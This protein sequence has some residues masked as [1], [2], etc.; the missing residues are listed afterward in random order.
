M[1]VERL[2]IQNF[3][4]FAAASFAPHTE[5]NLI[6]GPN[7]S[8][9]TTLLE[10]MH[11]LGT[12]RSFRVR[13]LSPL[14]RH[15]EEQF[16]LTASVGNPRQL[17]EAKT[18]SG[19]LE[20]RINEQSARGT[21]ELAEILP[22]LALHPEMHALIEGA[23]EGRRRFLDWGAF[24]VKHGYLDAWRSY[25]R[26]LR[27]RNA[28]L[29]A[30]YSARELQAWDQELVRFGDLL[31]R[32]RH[33]YVEQLGCAFVDLGASLLSASVELRYVRGWGERGDL[34]DALATSAQR[35][36]Q[37]GTTHVGPHR[38]DLQIFF[39]STP[40]RHLASRGQQKMLAFALGL[41]QAST[42]TQTS[43]RRM[44]LLVDDPSAE[45]DAERSMRI[46]AQLERIPSQRLV[47]ALM[48]ESYRG[49][50][51][52]VFHVKQSTL[53]QVI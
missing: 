28:I 12:G 17:I 8:G 32:L 29:K 22:V 44:V 16:Q 34:A 33:E 20:L 50:V 24:H 41:A 49:R 35:D 19:R 46:A 5:T 43:P 6:V 38:A 31:N 42:I 10:A 40:A 53:L 15:G 27:Q 1:S 26:S 21:A 36:Q 7:G 47:T 18:S 14:I 37:F 52:R 11:V 3:R 45:I 39:D 25:H 2:E 4:C 9:K 13:D 23:P 48:E 30:S 51:D